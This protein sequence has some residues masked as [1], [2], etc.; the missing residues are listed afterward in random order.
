MPK[1]KLAKGD[2]VAANKTRRWVFSSF[3]DTL[4]YVEKHKKGTLIGVL[5]GDIV[6]LDSKNRTTEIISQNEDDIAS[7]AIEVYE[8]LFE[9]LD[10]AYVLAGTEAHVGKGAWL[11]SNFASN[12]DNVVK[13]QETGKNLYMHLPL[14]LEGVKLDIMHHPKGGSGARPMNSQGVIDRLASDTVFDYANNREDPPDLVIRSH[15]H[16]YKDSKDAFATRAIITPAMCQSS[17]YVYRIGISRPA[18]VGCVLVYCENGEYEV[19]PVLV[20]P[21][22]R[23]WQVIK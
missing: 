13:N 23:K 19:E 17:S 6:E 1:V 3:C 10:M 18:S 16:E 14:N 8:P 12:F 9:M 20:K 11:E 5:N 22:Q 21:P 4:D 2:V 15:L 7:M